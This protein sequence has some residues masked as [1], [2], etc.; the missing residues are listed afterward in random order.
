M[1]KYRFTGPDGHDYEFE[2]DDA[3]DPNEVK[4]QVEAQFAPKEP[5]MGALKAGAIG[6]SQ[7]VTFGF[8]DEIYGGVAGAY[9]ALT[10]NKTFSQAYDDRRDAARAAL[11]KAREDQPFAAYGGEIVGGVA[12]PL[13]GARMAANAL[14]AAP[15]A[16]A[17][18]NVA[19]KVPGVSRGARAMSNALNA[20]GRLERG[21]GLGARMAAGAKEGAAWGGLYGYGS[22]EGSVE[23]RLGSAA[24]GAIMGGGFG[25]ALPMAS[26][27][28]RAGTRVVTTPM[29]AYRQPET[30][31]AEKFAQNV[32][33]DAGDSTSIDAIRSALDKLDAR[34]RM[35]SN[36]SDPTTII[37]DLGG[38]NMQGFL[39]AAVDTPSDA[40]Q[41]WKGLLDRRQKLQWRNLEANLAGT[42]ADPRRYKTT[43]D[44]IESVRK[45]KGARLFGN[46]W[47]HPFNVEPDSE[48]SRFMNLPY[49]KRLV[50]KTN[51]NVSGMTG[52]SADDVVNLISKAEPDPA[53]LA[54]IAKLRASVGKMDKATAESVYDQ[55][56]YYQSMRQQKQPERLGSFIVRT[57]G[58]ADDGKEIRHMV[59]RPK[60]RPGLVNQ[61]GSSLDDAALRAWEQGYFPNHTTRPTLRE[62]LDALDDDLR[63]NPVYRAADA[64]AVDDV[65]VASQMGDDLAQMGISPTAKDANVRA[66]LGIPANR[67]AVHAGPEST[68]NPWQFLHRVKMQIDTEIG[69]LKRGMPDNNAGWT[70][71]DLQTLKR[72]FVDAVKGHNKEYGK[73]IDAWA[74]DSAMADAIAD[75][76]EMGLRA[77]VEDVA[78]HMRGLTEGERQ[79]FRIGALRELAKKA[80]AKGETHNVTN[81]FRTHDMRAR[82]QVLF[83]NKL[84]LR[85]FWRGLVREEKKAGT[86]AASY[87]NSKTNKYQKFS[88]DSGD[89]AL[90]GAEAIDAAK[91][92][93][94]FNP[95]G[96][97]RNAAAFG[98]RFIGMPPDVATEVLRLAR[99]PAGQ[100]ID[101]SLYQ[102][103][104]QI[105][106]RSN[107]QQYDE[108]LSALRGG[109]AA[110]YGSWDD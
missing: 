38:E 91:N 24:G 28:V 58:I 5:A 33:R 96:L 17:V 67:A 46:A 54:E 35:P 56:K 72:Q 65:A 80:D 26:D 29:R 36:A 42:V 88:E 62:F 14:R 82:M 73:A 75:G 105:A 50:E 31:A 109:F 49:M 77:P 107:P 102:T 40:G 3:M 10:S 86:R 37:G 43:V 81:L 94:S 51:A 98:R 95:S 87:G 103:M 76:A 92:V 93:T 106:R 23:D 30:Y 84:A 20:T 89:A 79:L 2:A 15:G 74:G 18:A 108:A 8:G 104:P 100:G 101:P 19:S 45:E 16:T 83:E 1:A 7:G 70:I 64:G 12:L 69:N 60:D 25:A 52:K 47:K 63:G 97:L 39:R 90:L 110:G 66:A 21:A 53:D 6:A 71:N 48:L 68:T 85:Q 55:F 78:A 61:R 34:A 59:G 57:G 44:A 11:D 32:A 99:R 27:I 13:G 4:R 22:G 41:A 9:D